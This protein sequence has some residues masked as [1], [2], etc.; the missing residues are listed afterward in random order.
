M[1][2][3]YLKVNTILNNREKYEKTKE[4]IKDRQ[5]KTKKIKQHNY[6]WR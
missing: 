3:S 6:K 2:A 4:D 1:D 5:K